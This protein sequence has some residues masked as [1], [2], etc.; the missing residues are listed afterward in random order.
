MGVLLCV[1]SELTMDEVADDLQHLARGL[2]GRYAQL[3]QI[4]M[5][6][7]QHEQLGSSGAKPG[8]KVPVPTPWAS[9]LDVDLTHQLHMCLVDVAM[10]VPAGRCISRCMDDMLGWVAF[11]AWDIAAT[12]MAMDVHACLRDMT[13]RLDAVSRGDLGMV[14]GSE[15]VA[16]LAKAGHSCSLDTLR[17]WVKRGHIHAVKQGRA[18]HYDLDQV[19]RH[20][21]I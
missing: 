11:H 20:V 3:C 17:Q 19:L 14:S 12:P 1:P 2:V 15:V 5:S 10:Y 18:N 16:Q 4:K 6:S 9:D 21:G 8:S 7:V 13:S